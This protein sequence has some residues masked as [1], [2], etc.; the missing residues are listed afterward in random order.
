M[1]DILPSAASRVADPAHKGHKPMRDWSKPL[2]QQRDITAP[3]VTSY[4]GA[5]PPEALA[6]TYVAP[7]S[8]VARETA[9]WRAPAAAPSS[10][11]LSFKQLGAASAPPPPPDGTNRMT[12]ADDGAA[13]ATFEHF[14]KNRSGFLDYRELKNALIYMRYDVSTQ[15]AI[16]LLRSYDDRPDGKLDLGEFSKLVADLNRRVVRPPAPPP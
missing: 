14:D 13:R 7:R 5:R 3:P 2:D 9:T 4:L 15:D 12:R 6:S 1:R 8:Q 10:A 11:G 16:E